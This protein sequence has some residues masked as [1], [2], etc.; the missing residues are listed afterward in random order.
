MEPLLCIACFLLFCFGIF[1]CLQWREAARDR[2]DF[3]A[4]RDWWQ[5]A[6]GD[7]RRERDK[8]H[9]ELI[10]A[11]QRLKVSNYDLDT[12]RSEKAELTRQRDEA[13]KTISANSAAFQKIQKAFDLRM[14]ELKAE[15]ERK[16]K[17][18]FKRKV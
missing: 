7:A 9:D 1:A 14:A 3:R 12:L 18:Q 5:D 10:A 2:D 11:S 6:C 15:L 16:T 17:G 13:I 4:S 8:L